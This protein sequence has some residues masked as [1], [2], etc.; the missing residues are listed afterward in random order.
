[1]ALKVAIANRKGGVG[2]TTLAIALAETFVFEHKRSSLIVDLDPQ[3]SASEILLSPTEYADR[4]EKRQVLPRVWAR[5]NASA[6]SIREVVAHARHSLIGR[7][8]VDLAIAANSTELWDVEL[9]QVRNGKEKQYAD[10]VAKTISVLE[11]DFDIVVFDC[12]PGK[13]I[14][15]EIAILQ[16]DMVLCPIIPE[17]LSVWGMDRMKEYFTSLEEAGRQVP[18]WKFV[19]SKFIGSRSE[20]RQQ[21]EHIR[22]EYKDHF[23]TE[24]PGL[25]GLG[26]REFVGL[27]QAEVLVKRIA[28]FR[29]NPDDVKNLEQFYGPAIAKQLRLMAR[30]VEKARP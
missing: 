6:K 24:R 18:P 17:R 14:A 27:D 16:S 13:T 25:L 8:N 22:S 5:Q 26:E 15:S 1:M 30:H 4:V 7:G 19:I 21:V 29:E 12:P 2:K 20:A 23:L 28:K 11:Q 9:D 3:S 10:A